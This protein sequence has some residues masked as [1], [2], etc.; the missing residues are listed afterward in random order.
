MNFRDHT[1]QHVRLT[2]LRF[3]A[4][5]PGYVANAS[6]LKS[7]CAAFGFVVT[8][9][10]IHTQIGWLDEQGL[11]TRSDQ[12]ELILATLT[13]RGGDVAAGRARVEGVARPGPRLP[14]SGTAG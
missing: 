1:D 12:G 9:D 6:I 3:L 10:Q 8:R 7:V 4:E 13:E 14:G 5:A 2:I 11:V